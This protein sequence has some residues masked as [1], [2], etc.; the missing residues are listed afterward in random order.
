M[1]LASIR[2]VHL[3]CACG[4]CCWVER[5]VG[6]C[7]VLFCS[8]LVTPFDA[9]CVVAAATVV[10]VVGD[11]TL[12]LLLLA[13]VGVYVVVAF[14]C[15]CPPMDYEAV[16]AYCIPCCVSF[17]FRRQMCEL[18]EM[19]GLS[20]WVYSDGAIGEATNPGVMQRD[21]SHAAA[22]R[23]I[24]LAQLECGQEQD[25]EEARA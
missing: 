25:P 2:F 17:S 22:T 19:D 6:F 3:D 13:M 10:V 16:R 7:S 4:C 12:V 18:V 21:L 14:A 9:A 1:E 23:R 24:V 15:R 5:P 11:G 20:P 8:V